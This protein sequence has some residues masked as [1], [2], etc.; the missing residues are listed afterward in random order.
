MT[1]GIDDAERCNGVVLNIDDP[2][3]N[4]RLAQLRADPRIDF[5]DNARLNQPALQ[6]L[7]PM[8]PPEI[9]SS[10]F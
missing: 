2:V 7:R 3:D 10:D 5:I 6:R 1:P 9:S 8:P 4:E